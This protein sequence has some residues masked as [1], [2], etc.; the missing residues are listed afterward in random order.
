MN[1]SQIYRKQHEEILSIVSEIQK[2]LDVKII[3]EK[4]DACLNLLSE[5]SAKI[6]THL[7]M[8]D[9]ALYPKLL[10]SD[11][12][13]ARETAETYIQEMGG[14]KEVFQ[15]FVGKWSNPT[16]LRQDPEKFI[17]ETNQLFQALGER[18]ERENTVLY[19]LLDSL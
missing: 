3:Q 17:T 2:N 6:V 5:L 9:K 14:I 19:P 18:I 15:A 8:E 1:P 7:T 16:N 10:K 11:N 12:A 13:K 4:T